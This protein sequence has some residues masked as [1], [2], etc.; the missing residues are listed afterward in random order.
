MTQKGFTLIEF[1]VVVFC[2]LFFVGIGV[3][4][5]IRYEQSFLFSKEVNEL[6]DDL[7][8]AKQASITEQIQHAIRFN[9]EENRYQM[10]KKDETE[11][12]IKAKIFP[13]GIKIEEVDNYSEINFTKFG[14]VLRSGKVILSG[15]DFSKNII[16][17]P[18][19]FIY[20]ERINSN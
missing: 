7:K 3:L 13:T 19:G 11:E 8:Y 2:L 5:F 4:A 17:K 18:S 12:V 10:I 15:K 14:A 1:I 9:F 16:I 6:I 20:V